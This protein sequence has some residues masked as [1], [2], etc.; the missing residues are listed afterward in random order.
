MS[1]LIVKFANQIYTGSLYSQN[2]NDYENGGVKLLNIFSNTPP[3]TFGIEVV[4]VNEGREIVFVF[5]N[6]L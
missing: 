2:E 3:E 4:M 1:K 5:E 6:M